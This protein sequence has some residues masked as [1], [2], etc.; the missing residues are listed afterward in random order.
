MRISQ[1]GRRHSAVCLLP[2]CVFSLL[3][4]LPL[5]GQDRTSTL[6]G[7]VL[8]PAG[9]P[10]RQATVDVLDVARN[11]ARQ[12]TTDN[13]GNYVLRPLEVGTYRVSVSA[14]G[15]KSSTQTGVVLEVSRVTRLVQ[16]LE[17]GDTQEN[18]TVES[19]GQLVE[20]HASVVSSFVN[21]KAIEEL[22]LN[23]R[24]YIR[25]AALDAGVP[26][27]RAQGSTVFN[28]YGLPLKIGRAH[29]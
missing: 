3:V 16:R 24:D 25:L 21:A 1:G 17:I 28:G 4:A 19:E 18:I 5:T 22:P 6:S 12:A 23:G 26:V 13:E 8:D 9:L 20:T 14:R 2:L 10:V 7:T 27:A 29:V 11:A 15:F